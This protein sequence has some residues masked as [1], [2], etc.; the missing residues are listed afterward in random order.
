MSQKTDTQA[1]PARCTLKA[2][3]PPGGECQGNRNKVPTVLQA[4]FNPLLPT[5]G[6]PGIKREEANPSQVQ[7]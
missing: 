6:S 3:I 2:G 1:S 4:A 5:P 7:S